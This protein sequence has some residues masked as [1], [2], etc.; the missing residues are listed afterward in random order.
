[1]IKMFKVLIILM[2][3]LSLSAIAAEKGNKADLLLKKLQKR[4]STAKDIKVKE[5][6]I[7]SLYEVTVDTKIFYVSESGTFL[8]VGHMW[9]METNTNLSMNAL[10]KVRKKILDGMPESNM[11]VFSPPKGKVKHTVTVFTDL[12]CHYCRLMH[13][14]IAG[15]MK[16][17]IKV[18][19]VLYPR[20]AKNQ[21]SYTKAISVWCADNKSTA[22]TNAKA[23]QSIAPKSC[24]NPVDGNVVVGAGLGIRGT[25]AIF[26][27]N[28]RIIPGYVD[29][30]K[31][32]TMLK[33]RK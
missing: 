8:I 25:P 5:S 3:T 27:N 13:S 15:Y 29:P 2:A 23:G 18:R 28:G 26:F 24:A 12:D 14:K 9:N 7:K 33:K 31:L 11:I 6:P 19:Y 20:A 22:F 16:L 1:M 10:E 4:F 32:I 17:G 30:A 21:P